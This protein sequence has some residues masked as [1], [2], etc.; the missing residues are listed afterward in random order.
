MIV[1]SECWQSLVI[2]MVVMIMMTIKKIICKKGY[3]C[4]DGYNDDVDLLIIRN[5]TFLLVLW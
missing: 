5:K 3:Q 2:L 1:I 4:D